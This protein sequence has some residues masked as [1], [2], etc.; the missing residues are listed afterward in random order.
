M[1]PLMTFIVGCLILAA[2]LYHSYDTKRKQMRTITELNA[3]TYVE[4][5]RDDMNS[6]VAITDALKAIIISGNGTIDNFEKISDNLMADFVQSI[7]IA[8]DGVVTEIYPTEGNE[9]GKIDLI[10]D[11]KRGEICRY[12]RDNNCVTMQGPFDLKQGGRGI[13]VR[14]PVYLET[15]DG[16]PVFWGF[17]IVIIRVP[18]IFEE[19]VQALTDFGYDYCLTKTVSPFSEEC[20][21]ISFSKENLENPVTYTF[22]FG[23]CTFY[24]AVTPKDGWNQLRKMLPELV[25]G[26]FIVFFLTGLVI[27][28][29]VIE[30]HREA[31][32]KIAITDP[33]TGLLNRKGFEEQ[34]KSAIKDTKNAHCVGIQTDIDDFKFINDMYGHEAG[35]TALRI[36]AQSMRNAFEKGAILCRNGG[37]EFSAVLIGMTEAE[38]KEKIEKFTLQPRYITQN[39][40]KRQFYISL[41]YAEYPKDCDDVSELI[42]CADMA[43]YAVKLRGK[44]SCCAYDGNYKV[45]HRSQLGFAL[46]DVSRNLPGAFLIYIADKMDDRILFANQ[47]LIEF[48]GC[49]DYEEFLA[50]TDQRFRNLIHPEEQDA[51]ETSIW[52]QIDSEKS[53]NN[54][55]VKFRF[56]KKDGTYHPVFDHG[57]IVKNRYY[58][59]VFYVLIMDCALVESYYDDGFI[60]LIFPK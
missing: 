13:A 22:E 12:G 45:Q 52:K 21:R 47:E 6:G 41:G 34:I 15:S 37:D 29:L 3:S 4:R 44:H 54:D 5:L 7:Q 25:L 42:S 8:P 31:L 55:Y 58:G 59:N 51:V 17:T 36:L 23:G 40:E 16:N 30:F 57:R 50:Y 48:A 60:D 32:K 49:K 26:F 9:E 11:E 39:G 38:V 28:I 18:E 27:V 35:D 43:L 46:Q 2:F 10:H 53:G 19:S 14:N 56:A 33:L 1:L 24:L 20:E